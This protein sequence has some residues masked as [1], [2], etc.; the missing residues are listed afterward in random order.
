MIRTQPENSFVISSAML[1][2]SYIGYKEYMKYKQS[3]DTQTIKDVL[4]EHMHV[5]L[6]H[7]QRLADQ[8]I[9]LQREF[10]KAD[11]DAYQQAMTHLTNF[12]NQYS[13]LLMRSS[14]QINNTDAHNLLHTRREFLNTLYSFHLKNADISHDPKFKKIVLTAHAATYRYIEILRNKHP[15]LIAVLPPMPQSIDPF[16]KGTS[17][18]IT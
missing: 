7:N 8:L 1:V 2:M 12:L 6:N 14:N 15:M 5:L 9:I 4:G 16:G 11:R 13:K 10:A 17:F 3:G 18:D